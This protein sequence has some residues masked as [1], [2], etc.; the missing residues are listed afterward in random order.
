MSK[1]YQ[2][3]L[4][5]C[6]LV[7]LNVVVYFDVTEHPFVSIDDIT[8]VIENPAVEYGLGWRQTVTAFRS[9]VCANWIPMTW[10]SHAFDVEF[11][12]MEAP[13]AHHATSLFLHALNTCL[14]FLVLL[15]FFGRDAIWR[16]ATVAALFAVH[17]T[18]VET[19]AW[20]TERKGVLSTTFWWLA[21]AAYAWHTKRPSSAR[22]AVVATALAASL[23]S[24]GM[25]VSLPIVLLLL[26]HWPLRRLERGDTWRQLIVEKIP[27]LA[28][29][30]AGMVATFVAQNA[31][32]AVESLDE[33]PLKA[34]FANAAYSYVRYLVMLIWPVNLAVFYPYPSLE[35]LAWG[36]RAV[37]V[38]T[39][40][41]AV[42]AGAIAA[43]ATRPWWTLGWLWY[44]VTLVPVIG[45]VKVGEHA[46]SD[47][48]VYI[49]YTGLFIALVWTLS[50]AWRGRAV[51][52]TVLTGLALVSI[53]TSSALARAQ[54]EHW[55]SSF[56]L[57]KRAVT[58]T[59]NSAVA[60]HQLGNILLA[61]GRPEDALPFVRRSVELE[62]DSAKG[63]Q[64][65]GAVL[66]QLGDVRAAAAEFEAALEID[67]E[68]PVAVHSLALVAYHDGRHDLAVRRFWSRPSST[69]ARR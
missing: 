45:I 1:R 26:D 58:V 62:P 21:L 19:V 4:I 63:R 16:C 44:L 13:G 69:T 25:A 30:L 64:N 38:A 59:R 57:W 61:A 8:C 15:A 17:P 28:L 29:V 3:A 55:E 67:P 46:I 14:A 36:G 7:T 52:K 31:G 32:G 60:Y 65:L 12:G 39:A 24:K 6:A 53:I 27:L 22:L 41:F 11:F 43:A 35:A 33:I 66:L 23:L 49:P 10:L 5:C 68:F 40:L 51:G 48:Y 56:A 42:T 2:P 9:L 20:I 54:V 34:R 47:R 18:H 37:A 50:D